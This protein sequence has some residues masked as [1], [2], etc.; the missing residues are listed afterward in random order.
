MGRQEGFEK[1]I[2]A[3]VS[4]AELEDRVQ[5]AYNRVINANPQVAQSLRSFYPDITDGDILAYALDPDKALSSIK[6]K[7]TSAEIGAG[8]IMAG[9]GT[10]LAT[11]RKKATNALSFWAMP[12]SVP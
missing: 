9:L 6:R 4:P 8:A 10:D 5:T 12:C 11:S 2:G 7:V 3:D 1:F